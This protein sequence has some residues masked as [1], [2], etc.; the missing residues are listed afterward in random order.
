VR[1][2]EVAGQ[3]L[4]VEGLAEVYAAVFME[5]PWSEPDAGDLRRRLPVHAE[6]PGFRLVAA[7]APEGLVGFAYGYTGDAAG[8][9]VD[10]LAA[11]IGAE[12]AGRLVGGHLVLAEL[13]VVPAARGRGTGRALLDAVLRDRPEPRVLLQT[14]DGAT[15]A[16]RLYE[17]AGF[18]RLATMPPDAVL[19][20]ELP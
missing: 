19:V 13:A 16:M 6:R 3:D 1:I 4:D 5:P 14:R 9:W 17:R 15:P 2:A 8:A 20:K 7:T 18:R 12:A 11:R 10:R